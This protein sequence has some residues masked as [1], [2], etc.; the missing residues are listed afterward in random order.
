MRILGLKTYQVE[1]LQIARILGRNAG[2]VRSLRGYDDPLRHLD[3]ANQHSVFLVVVVSPNVS[4][5]CFVSV[6]QPTLPV[7]VTDVE[8]EVLGSVVFSMV[9]LLPRIP[10]SFL[11]VVVVS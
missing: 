7:V 1:A 9:V 8:V 4:V 10:S 5:F 11:I 6:E 3:N 2:L